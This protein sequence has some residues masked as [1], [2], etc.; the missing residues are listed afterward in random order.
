MRHASGIFGAT[1]AAC[2]LAFKQCTLRGVGITVVD[3]GSDEEQEECLFEDAEDA[4]T[5]AMWG[6][7]VSLEFISR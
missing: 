4:G 7:F 5:D 2:V 6:Q 1:V 3:D